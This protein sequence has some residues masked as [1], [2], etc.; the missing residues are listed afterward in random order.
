VHNDARRSQWRDLTPLR[1]Y[2]HPEEVAGTAVFLCSDDALINENRNT[3]LTT[4]K[5]PAEK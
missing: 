2:A 5:T 1:R 3:R 4:T